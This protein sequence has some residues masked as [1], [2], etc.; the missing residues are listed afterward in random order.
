MTALPALPRDLQRH[1][2][3]FLEKPEPYERSRE[4]G[5]I[6]SIARRIGDLALKVLDRY[7][8]E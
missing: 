5:F 1:E 2:R 4:G 8:S 6:L 7:R 3:P